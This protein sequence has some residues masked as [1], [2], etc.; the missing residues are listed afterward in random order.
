MDQDPEDLTPS[1]IAVLASKVGGAADRA[2]RTRTW[3]IS[4]LRLLAV[5]HVACWQKPATGRGRL[6]MR[7]LLCIIISWNRP[8]FLRRTLESLFPQIEDIDALVVIVD[9]CSDSKA[10]V[11]RK[12]CQERM[13]LPFGTGPFIQRA[14]PPKQVHSSLTSLG[15][16]SYS[17]ATCCESFHFRP[18]SW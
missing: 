4:F 13:A 15:C 10:R 2:A 3:N 18:V 11:G 5:T 1:M 9:N 16:Q 6:L 8:E 7:K 14:T 12:R 17:G